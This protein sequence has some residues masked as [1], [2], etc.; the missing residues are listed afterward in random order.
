MYNQCNRKMLTKMVFIQYTY[1]FV[2]SYV[3]AKIRKEEKIKEK[4][5]MK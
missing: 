1:Y 2:H 4:V 3:A 5:T